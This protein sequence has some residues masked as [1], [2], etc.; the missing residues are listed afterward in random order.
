MIGVRTHASVRKIA[1]FYCPPCGGL[2]NHSRVKFL[3]LE[4]T[5]LFKA[6]LFKASLFKAHDLPGGGEPGSFFQ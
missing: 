3:S 2:H 6:V 1:C 4:Y 5:A